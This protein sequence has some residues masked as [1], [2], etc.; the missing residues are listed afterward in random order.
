M[1]YYNRC[2]SQIKKATKYFDIDLPENWEVEMEFI[3]NESEET[4]DAILIDEDGNQNIVEQ[5][6]VPELGDIF[7]EEGW[8]DLGDEGYSHVDINTNTV[9]VKSFETENPVQTFK[10][11]EIPQGSELYKNLIN[12]VVINEFISWEAIER[13]VSHKGFISKI[14]VKLTKNTF[15]LPE[16]RQGDY[17]KYVPDTTVR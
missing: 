17:Y 2:G 3:P 9:Q 1:R 15:T 6:F 5:F 4:I 7:I 10:S 12:N 16:Y 14:I 13:E 11:D 8:A